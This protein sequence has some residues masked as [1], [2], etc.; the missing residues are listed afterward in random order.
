M[1]SHR[2]QVDSLFLDEGFGT[3]DEEALDVALDTLTN[4]QQSGKLI[5]VISHIQ[6]LKDRISSQIQVVPQIGG[7]SKIIGAGI[8]KISWRSLGLVKLN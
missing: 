1:A 7:I 6:A 2:M 3:L 5:G 4:L 8:T